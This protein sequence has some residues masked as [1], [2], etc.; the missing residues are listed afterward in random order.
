MTK[1]EGALDILELR[2][3]DHSY[4]RIGELLGLDPRTVRKY[5]V[6]PELAFS[7]RHS[8]SRSSKLDPFLGNVKAWLEEDPGYSARW[9]YDHLRPMAYTG[10][11]EIVKR[12]VRQLKANQ[13]RVAYDR[14]ETEPGRQAQVDWAEFGVV[15]PDGGAD[16][17]YCFAMIL[18]YSREPY[19]ELVRHCDLTTF[20]DCHIRA[21][22]HFGGVPGEILYDRMKNVYLGRLAGS[23]AFNR[24]LTSLAV[25]YRFR[26]LVAPAAAPWVKG[27][28]E[29]PI[30]FIREGF[31]RGYPF[32]S[33]EQANR[34]LMAW[35]DMKS[36]RI[37]GTTHERVRDRFLREKPTLGQ[38][39][40]AAFDTSYRAYRT[41][42]KDCAV[43]FEANRFMA[44]HTIVGKEVLLRVKDK[45]LR[46]FLDNEHL[47]TYEI[48]EGKGSFVRDP[49]FVAALLADREMN[50]KKYK[51]AKHS[52]KGKA[53]TISP[54]VPPWALEVETRPVDIYELSAE[55]P[56]LLEVA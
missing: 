23:P 55:D 46:M 10:G 45:C 25:H 32:H 36:D 16:T 24:S 31:W 4:R 9:V 28:I 38:L 19:G 33:V 52:S 49:R 22:E 37:H 44:P 39:P 11:Y 50:A 53:K 34:D 56:A 54:A 1:K 47:V 15:R 29:Q 26:C 18:G 51:N 7:E 8:G 13:T 41:V 48:P 2:R 12:L 42:M 17:L 40:C 27:K 43:H 6:C 14:F 20:L 3:T 30:G 35:I 5:A 21:F